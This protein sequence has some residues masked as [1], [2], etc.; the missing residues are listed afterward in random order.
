MTLFG[1]KGANY[2][3]I[4]NWDTQL[5]IQDIDKEEPNFRQQIDIDARQ[6]CL[7]Y[8]QNIMYLRDRGRYVYQVDMN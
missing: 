1:T 2:E 5:I 6:I 8:Q 3:I 7:D 4:K